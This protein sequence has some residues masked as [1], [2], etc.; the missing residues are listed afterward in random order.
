MR[1]SVSAAWLSLF[2]VAH[3]GSISSEP[4][5]SGRFAFY[6]ATCP[7]F[8]ASN[9]SETKKEWAF[10]RAAFR[11]LRTSELKIMNPIGAPPHL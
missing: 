6:G 7:R 3:C 5:V 8:G 9:V 10:D 1:L 2:A 11:A 4:E